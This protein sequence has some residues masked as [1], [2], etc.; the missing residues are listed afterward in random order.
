ML[1]QRRPP[2]APRD[3]DA[4]RKALCEL[5]GRR[6]ALRYKTVHRCFLG[7]DRD[8]N[9][10]VDR[11][12]L[13]DLFQTFNL[14]SSKADRLFDLMDF[15]GSGVI[16]FD[17]LRAMIGPHIQPGYKAPSRREATPRGSMQMR[18]QEA[19]IHQMCQ[20]IGLKA[21]L[22]Y[23]N[24]RDCFRFLDENKDG[25]VSAEEMCRFVEVFGF[26]R[27][28]GFPLH[29][30]L[31][32][33]EASGQE[34]VDYEAFMDFFSPFIRPGHGATDSVRSDPSRRRP[35]SA[36]SSR[37]GDGGSATVDWQAKLLTQRLDGEP[38]GVRIR[39]TASSIAS[40]SEQASCADSVSVASSTPTVLLEP[41]ERRY[42]AEVFNAPRG[43]PVLWLPERQV[44]DVVND[45]WHSGAMAKLLGSDG[46]VARK[47]L[48]TSRSWHGPFCPVQTA[49]ARQEAAAVCPRP[50]TSA[51]PAKDG[52][53]ARIAARGP[54]RRQTAGCAPGLDSRPGS[55]SKSLEALRESRPPSESFNLLEEPNVNEAVPDLG[56]SSGPPGS[57]RPQSARLASG[58]DAPRGR[59]ARSPRTCLDHRGAAVF[60]VCETAG[61]GV[62][63]ALLSLR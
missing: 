19:E 32:R 20:T 29:S 18:K 56:S 35:Q 55:R 9:G 58:K 33:R 23:R 15:D 59:A 16:S 14:P 47:C 41:G 61:W 42:R 60:D 39:S 8:H 10:W 27:S 48:R 30:L 45:T 6:A 2:T 36:R 37:S 1:L 43:E 22:K 24:A 62:A 4:E 54:V 38:A 31:A 26:P 44:K 5:V 3:R 63:N 50:P 40:A 53:R 46:P 7:L 51:R 25:M 49:S 34:V 52:P 57:R 17:E 13:R 28:M 12:E 11:P 21:Y